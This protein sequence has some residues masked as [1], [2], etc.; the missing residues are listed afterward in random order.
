MSIKTQ[1]WTT[2]P[3]VA[4][5]LPCYRVTN[6]VPDVIAKIGPEVSAIFAVDDY[7]PDGSSVSA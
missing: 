6:H 1:L 2:E 5:V 4:V 3:I 7:C